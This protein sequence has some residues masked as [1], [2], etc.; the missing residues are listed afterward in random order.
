MLHLGRKKVIPQTAR[1]LA[2]NPQ[3]YRVA[4]LRTVE[5]VPL[6]TALE[7]DVS[8]KLLV[9]A[10]ETGGHNRCLRRSNPFERVSRYGTTTNRY[11]TLELNVPFCDRTRT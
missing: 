3:R 7:E 4:P 9:R 11:G 8:L 10:G 5:E 2:I 1:S 6:P